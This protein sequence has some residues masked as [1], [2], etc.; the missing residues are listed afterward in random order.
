MT[1]EILSC[2]FVLWAY[3][4]RGPFSFYSAVYIAFWLKYRTVKYSA[5]SVEDQG[6]E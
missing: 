2:A 5:D 3:L 6:K 4:F 1:F